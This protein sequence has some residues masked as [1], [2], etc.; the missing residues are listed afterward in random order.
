M[1]I[2][3]RHKHIVPER[4][5][6]LLADLLWTRQRLNGRMIK[7]DTVRGGWLAD[8]QFVKVSDGSEAANDP[9]E[10][11][12]SCICAKR[13][14]SQWTHQNHQ[15]SVDEQMRGS[16]QDRTFVGPRD[17]RARAIRLHCWVSTDGH[18]RKGCGACKRM[19]SVGKKLSVDM[20]C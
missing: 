1:H 5:R 4:F 19:R 15:V 9:S 3:P 18:C 14:I 17:N 16:V 10:F 7:S 2:T 11:Q 12:P 8:K 6:V 13:F 20:D